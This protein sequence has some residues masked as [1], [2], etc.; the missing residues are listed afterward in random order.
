[1]RR[2][3]TANRSGPS[4]AESKRRTVRVVLRLPPEA[5]EALKELATFRGKTR[6]VVVDALVIE[7]L[8]AARP[9]AAR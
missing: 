2:D 7:A 9:W 1:M 8:R 3:G 5:A 6:S 4:V